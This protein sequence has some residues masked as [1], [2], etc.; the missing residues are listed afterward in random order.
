MARFEV[1]GRVSYSALMKIYGGGSELDLE[2]ISEGKKLEKV[3]MEMIRSKNIP[4]HLQGV[5]TE[6]FRHNKTDVGRVTL[7][8]EDGNSFG[9]EFFIKPDFVFDIGNVIDVKLGGPEPCHVIQAA[10]ASRVMVEKY[11][12]CPNYYL[13]TNGLMNLCWVDLQDK[14]TNRAF[15]KFVIGCVARA[16]LQVTGEGCGGMF[17][18]GEDVGW[19]DLLGTDDD[20]WN[21]IGEAFLGINLSFLDV[22][23]N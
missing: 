1:Q 4:P 18:G 3:L 11:G 15:D 6:R 2:A 7:T 20:I 19:N 8:G 13:L 10:M 9:V 5:V 16:G 17:V 23:S 14:V 12:Y 22:S 21:S